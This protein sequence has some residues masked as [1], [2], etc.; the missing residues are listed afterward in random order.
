MGPELGEETEQYEQQRRGIQRVTVQGAGF[1]QG[2]HPRL[3]DDLH[4]DQLVDAA[5]D[6]QQGNAQQEIIE[7]RCQAT[8][9]AGGGELALG[10]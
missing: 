6:N 10:A 5:R 9:Q 2:T 1:G 7:H 8:T 3:A 4:L